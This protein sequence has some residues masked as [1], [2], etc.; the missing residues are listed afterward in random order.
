MI[1]CPVCFTAPDGTCGIVAFV[2]RY[3]RCLRFSF[4]HQH[5]FVAWQFVSSRLQ[6]PSRSI[7]M[8]ANK[9]ELV[10][11]RFDPAGYW[12]PVPDDERAP[13]VEEHLELGR[14]S[15]VLES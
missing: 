4:S 13:V 3:C 1:V 6:S 11:K 2:E 15:L 12:E 10:L 8:V 9:G 14:A 7:A 5:D